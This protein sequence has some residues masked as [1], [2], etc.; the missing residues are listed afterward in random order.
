M[1]KW[2]I[3]TLL[4]LS[5]GAA[6]IG[7]GFAQQQK[8]AGFY[9]LRIYTALPGKRDALAARFASRT[10][11]IYGR[12]GITNVGYWIPQ[13][14]DSELGISAENTF[15]YMRAIRRERRGTSDSRQ[16]TMTPSLARL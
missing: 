3:F 4:G 11:A 1:L 7:W 5:F 12:H 2:K 6:G 9:E 8:A 15:I 16:P 14:S 13:Q 10:A